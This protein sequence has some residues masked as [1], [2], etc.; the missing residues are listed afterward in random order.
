MSPTAPRP[1]PDTRGLFSLFPPADLLAR[2]ELVAPEELPEPYY[3]LLVHEHHMTVTV[4]TYHGD[5]VDVE[6]LEEH[7]GQ[8]A[9]A[10]KI[11][12]RLRQSR[13]VVLFGLVRVHFRYC[14]PV[15]RDEIIGGR[16]PLGRILINHNVLRHVMPTAFLRVT[17]APPLARWFGLSEP[18]PT[19]GRLALI[20]CDERPAIEVLE[21]V[22][23]E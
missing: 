14:N 1:G 3:G 18:R 5:A 15:V 6:I 19:Y 9:Y 10:R 20:Q 16:T 21:I 8:H 13:R 22:T 4:E 7:R 2:S 11:L 12:L 17:P 23:P